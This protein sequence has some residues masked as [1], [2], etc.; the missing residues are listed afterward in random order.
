MLL[1]R[2]CTNVILYRRLRI[3]K[4]M[5]TLRMRQE[6]AAAKN[7]TPRNSNDRIKKDTNE[8]TKR[9]TATQWTI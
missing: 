6:E 9:S 4:E 2:N 8:A 1:V 3:H 5:M 7:G